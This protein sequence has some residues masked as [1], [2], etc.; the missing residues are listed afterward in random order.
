MAPKKKKKKWGLG[1]AEGGGRPR[2]H[3]AQPI[4]ERKDRSLLDGLEPRSR[5]P[6]GGRVSARSR[7]AGTEDAA[8]SAGCAR[9][10]PSSRPCPALPLAPPA[11]RLL[12][13]AVAP[14]RMHGGPSPAPPGAA[15][16]LQRRGPTQPTE[17]SRSGP[18][19]RAVQLG[20]AERPGGAGCLEQ[21]RVPE[22]RGVRCRAPSL[23]APTRDAR[24]G[25]R[26][27]LDI[28]G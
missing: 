7:G 22:Q 18:L 24:Q 4:P 15:P 27:L 19:G 5:R 9:P 26:V 14:S 21:L 13:T 25:Q 1:G 16:R 28:S 2:A 12:R 8:L 3:A 23:L 20:R 10:R 6:G 17:Q 11:G